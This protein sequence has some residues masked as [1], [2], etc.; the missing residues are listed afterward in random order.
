MAIAGSVV[1]AYR[2]WLEDGKLR[3]IPTSMLR[4]MCEAPDVAILM[5]RSGLV[6]TVAGADVDEVRRMVTK[7]EVGT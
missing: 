6:A 7:E 5:I 3:M 2:C 4:D 1:H